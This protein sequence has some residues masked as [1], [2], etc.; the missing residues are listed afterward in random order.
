[1]V[2]QA[3]EHVLLH[4]VVQDLPEAVVATDAATVITVWNRA[5]ETIFG[6]SEDEVLG[7]SAFDLNI[8][9]ANIGQTD[10]D[11][12]QELAR[13]IYAGNSWDGSLPAYTKYGRFVLARVRAVP[14]RAAHGDIV[15][16]VVTIREVLDPQRQRR[17]AEE[18]IG[19]LSRAGML[20]GTSL[21]IDKTLS[22]IGD[23]LVP[24]LADHCSIDVYDDPG[25]L[26]RLVT[27]Q[28]AELG[29]GQRYGPPG[30]LV[31][32][33]PGHPCARALDTGRAV[34]VDAPD[35]ITFAV[36]D[37]TGERIDI[38]SLIAVP[39][40]GAGKPRGVLTM[41]TSV[42]GRKY[43][44]G[45]VDLVEELAAR[46]SMALDNAELYAR[47]RSLALTLQRSL[48]PAGLPSADGLRIAYRYEPGQDV[49]VSGDLYDVVSLSAGRLGFVIGDVQGRGARAAAIMGQLRAA[50]RAYAVLDLPPAE[51]LGHL[52]ELV[53]GLDEG[54]LVTC[55]YAVYDPF[56][57]HCAFGN[58]GHPPPLLI[59]SDVPR[60]L[61]ADPDVPLGIGQPPYTDHVLTVPPGGTLLLYTDGVVA[62]RD[63]SHRVTVEEGVRR[64]CR[65]FDGVPA[66]P[67]T[68]CGIALR[69]APEPA[70][71]DRALLAVQTE[72]E[73]LPLRRTALQAVPEAAA[74][75]RRFTRDTF[76]GWGL[77][78]ASDLA[79][80]LVSEL[81]TNAVRHTVV[82]PLPAPQ[83]AGVPGTATPHPAGNV[84]REIDLAV[85][86]GQEALWVEVSD[87]DVRLPRLRIASPEDEGGRGLYLVDALS[88]R[89]G[90]RPTPNGKIVWFE[91]P[92]A[93][94]AHRFG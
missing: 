31:S 80:L 91:V 64:L 84:G 57:R 73:D 4:Q 87:R 43:E 36:G 11:Q 47:Q 60:V 82:P 46:A 54:L 40:V 85:R 71:D 83:T 32:Y 42:S 81:V 52:D 26:R 56:T 49:E 29:G 74:M 16:L 58:A 21:D 78:D 28:A 90:T 77:A 38:G 13:Q 10:I 50:L 14:L 27:V 68:V 88:A 69:A 59:D 41:A 48:L 45:D 23:L 53:R 25:W 79:E 8:G 51:V 30:G 20:L 17:T 70:R 55:V 6:W 2:D 24:G 15:G 34:L 75:A 62:R 12:A 9:Q 65:A 18:R 63:P 37:G 94:A 35:D 19:V 3:T 33:P 5:A 61:E 22:G 93:G 1:M 66:D 44:A 92:L 86:R 72:I 39:L 7:R 89:W 67:E 76:A